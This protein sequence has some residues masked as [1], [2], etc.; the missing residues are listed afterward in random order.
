M[1]LL[2]VCV[3][4]SKFKAAKGTLA[5]RGLSE[6][7]GLLVLGFLLMYLELLRKGW[8]DAAC[9]STYGKIMKMTHICRK[10]AAQ[11]S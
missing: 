11:A 4:E 7:S 8:K 1:P 6:F 9:Q 5:G 10:E 3:C 2:T